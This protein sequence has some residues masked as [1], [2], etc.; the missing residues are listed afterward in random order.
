MSNNFGVKDYQSMQIMSS[1]PEKLILML[2][3]G[4]LRFIQLAIKGMEK[5][6]IE[7]SHNNLIK[8][9][10]ILVELM[11]SLNFDKG[12]EIAGNL[13]RIYEFMHYTLVQANVKK[14]VEPVQRIHGQ[15]KKLRDSWY[16]AMKNIEKNN[17]TNNEN[18][19]RPAAGKKGKKNIELTG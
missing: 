4:A 15:L 8:T 1:K 18:K 7:L 14:E 17:V 3:D 10:N 19:N 2:Y 9:Q 16:Q 13:F 6:D 5:K 11:A 12:G